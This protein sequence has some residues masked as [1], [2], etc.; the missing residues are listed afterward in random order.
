MS[1]GS[2]HLIAYIIFIIFSIAFV[3][4]TEDELAIDNVVFSAS[5]ASLFI[6]LS[7]LF[8]TKMRTD[9]GEL[10]HLLWMIQGCNIEA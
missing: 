8:D 1:E 10:E 6:S 2:K 3:V 4:F 9:K 5:V 7:D